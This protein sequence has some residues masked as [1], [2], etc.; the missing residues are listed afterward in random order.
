MT[1]KNHNRRKRK[2]PV[3]K[4]MLMCPL[5]EVNWR[6]IYPM[7]VSPTCLVMACTGFAI[8]SKLLFNCQFLTY[9]L[10][11]KSRHWQLPILWSAF[12]AIRSQNT[13]AFPKKEFLP[14]F[15]LPCPYNMTYQRHVNPDCWDKGTWPR[16]AHGAAQP[17]AKAMLDMVALTSIAYS[18]HIHTWSQLMPRTHSLCSNEFI[19]KLTSSVY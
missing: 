19:L 5:L 7:R 4:N 13:V 1:P 2:K 11:P 9:C 8:Q 10:K 14:I 17:T 6:R 16:R 12:K 3:R 15:F 18:M